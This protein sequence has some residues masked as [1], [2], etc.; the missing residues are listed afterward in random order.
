MTMDITDVLDLA[1]QR[2]QAGELPPD[3]IADY[4]TYADFLYPLLNSAA[5]LD[6]IRPVEMP[7]PEVLLADRDDFL[8]KV[9]THQPVYSG[10]FDHLKLW[11]AQ[12]F[13]QQP[14]SLI[15]RRKELRP[16]S[17][18]LVRAM[19][20]LTLV[21]G[22]AGGAAVLAADSLPDSPL[23]PLKLT[24][25]QTRLTMVS[26]PAEQAY[27]HLS[28]AQ[29]R[30]EEVTRMALAGVV[31]DEAV[32]SRLQQHLNQALDLAAQTPD[33]DMAELLT[34]TQQMAQSQEQQLAQAKTSAAEQAHE[35]LQQASGI[36]AQVRQEAEDGLQG[37]QTFRWQ[38]GQGS[39]PEAAA[40]EQSQ[41]QNQ[42]GPGE[43]GPALERAGP[44]DGC[45]GDN[46]TLN[47]DE[48]GEQN[49]S[50]NQQGPGEKGPALEQTGPGDG[51]DGDNGTLNLDECGEQNQHQHEP[52]PYG[53]GPDQPGPGEP[54]GEGVNGGE[55]NN[56]EN[57]GEETGND[58][59]NDSSNGNGDDN[60]N[61]NQGGSDASDGGD[62]DNGG[63][64]DSGGDDG[65]S[66]DS[67]S[68]D[69]GSGDTG[70]SGGGGNG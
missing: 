21:F 60:D 43:K 62:N 20:V 25:E 32:L 13:P 1:L 52:G 22:S 40:G 55:N 4:P 5:M 37:P 47:L 8:F 46:G 11:A 58:N 19:L 9:T 69:G 41:N 36:L 44:G 66:E 42:Q 12:Y 33:D 48:C 49:Q 28:L 70:G 53:P 63:S 31:P 24:M 23:Y 56:G 30:A 14:I 54:D 16:M 39:P 18:L 29:T 6:S 68:D 51:C 2:L 7:A 67:G 59:D 26:D 57:N 38:H 17:T 61:D 64:E 50:Q 27:L 35:P 15:Y 65:G 10:W 34:H 3:I 45:D